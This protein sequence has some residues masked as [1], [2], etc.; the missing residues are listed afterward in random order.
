MKDGK[1]KKSNIVSARS[2]FLGYFFVITVVLLWNLFHCTNNSWITVNAFMNDD[3]SRAAVKNEENDVIEFY[4]DEPVI[5]QAEVNPHI[6]NG[7]KL[8]LRG[9]GLLGYENTKNLL[10]SNEVI[11]A[12]VKDTRTKDILG[13]GFTLL[14][15]HTT[16]SNSGT[17]I[18]IPLTEPV[19]GLEPEN[20]QVKFSSDGLKRNGIFIDGE[21]IESSTEETEIKS[22]PVARLYFE[23]K[24]WNPISP[25]LNYLVE[26]VSGLGCLLLFGDKRLPL[27]PHLETCFIGDSYPRSDEVYEKK[28]SKK[29]NLLRA[30]FRKPGGLIITI[31]LCFFIMLYT[32]LSVVREASVLS[33]AEVLTGGSHTKVFEL[34]PDLIVHQTIT[35]SENSLSGIGIMLSDEDKKTIHSVEEAD[36]SDAILQW[37]IFDEKGTDYLAG[38]TGAVK[39]LKQVADV[40]GKDI[41]EEVV[42][43]VA[44][45][46]FLLE[47]DNP[48]KESKGKH[49][50]LELRIKK[51]GSRQGSVYLISTPDTN[52]QIETDENRQDIR[53]MELCLMGVYTCNGF[54]KSMFVKM[55]VC[56]LCI[57]AALYF[58]ERRLSCLQFNISKRVALMYLVSAISM[59]MVFS[60]MT[61]AYTVSDERTHIDTV[62]ILSN[63]LLGIN[64]IPGPEYAFKRACDIDSSIKN[65]MSVTVARYRGVWE[66][67]FEEPEEVSKIGGIGD[68][69]ERTL[70]AAYTRNAMSNA[71]ALCYFPAA[72]GFSAARILGMNMITMVMAARWTNLLICVLVMYLALTNMPYGAA[73]MAIIGL[74]PKTLQQMASCSYDG[75]IIAVIFLFISLCLKA[76][77][78]NNLSIADLLLLHLAGFFTGSS[79]GGA[80][81]PILG[82]LLLIPVVI[83]GNNDGKKGGIPWPKICAI[84]IT[85]AI[86]LVLG[87]NMS[88][89]AGLAGSSPG[90][91]TNAGGTKYLYTLSD[92]IHA[93]MRL[94]QIY[95]NT[96]YKRGDGL[97][98]E[99]VGKNLSQKWYLV[100]LFIALAILGIIHSKNH[101]ADVDI[102]YME[103]EKPS[104]TR[105]VHFSISEK[106]W[107]LVLIAGS[108]S[109][110]FL[111]MLITFT[112]NDMN[113]ID[114]L[115]GRY[116]LPLAPLALLAMENDLIHRN[117]IKDTNLLY[118][119]D[120]LL[121]VTFC[122][123]MLH[124]LGG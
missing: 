9:V 18:Y 29:K 119:A 99:L 94:I 46:S 44:G 76:A 28:D 120:V 98:G 6:S 80:Y 55:C 67:L 49:F 51:Q 12:E 39:D 43:K 26:L 59:G 42:L 50:V 110:I 72:I 88:L 61:P 66:G 65:T 1:K 75:M 108:T 20:L 122:E 97:L 103:G 63:Q 118:A 48:I 27:L 101:S 54:L 33:D 73:G 32:Y 4:D 37:K 96:L 38:G 92:F 74:F 68:F 85:G 45:K 8:R 25:I 111:S 14:K 87:K 13:Q 115:Q 31:A 60:F 24:I 84:I 105:N 82:M 78:D 34:T 124:I 81:L 35:S 21:K 30:W 3:L 123:I 77:F 83:A 17:M 113:Y 15:N 64:D 70:T 121:V 57:I 86:I 41:S 19:A 114:G 56:L 22:I 40:L 91:A 53:P 106:L 16:Y 58:I 107:I 79:K 23:N 109:L 47:L 62:Y 100:Y 7:K 52:G 102:D 71:S 104:V 117:G 10:F 116:F 89:F 90:S 11:K 95:L 112:S 5:V 36:Y 69:S 2:F 93:P